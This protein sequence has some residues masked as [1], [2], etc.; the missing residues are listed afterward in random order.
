VL[1]A[2]GY[3]TVTFF[4]LICFASA[5]HDLGR[6]DPP[7]RLPYPLVHSRIYFFSNPRKGS[8]TPASSFPLHRDLLSASFSACN[9]LFDGL[10]STEARVRADSRRNGFGAPKTPCHQS[11][12]HALFMLRGPVEFSSGPPAEPGPRILLDFAL[13]M[14]PIFYPFTGSLN[15][16]VRLAIP[17]T[18]RSTHANA[19]LAY[20]LAPALFIFPCETGRASFVTFSPSLCRTGSAI[21]KFFARPE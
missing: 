12:P 10:R 8:Y 18:G 16:G 15:N 14:F 19:L 2:R 3:F 11:F 7:S 17:P 13:L 21:S 5:L 9:V 1:L 4:F 6:R 20:F